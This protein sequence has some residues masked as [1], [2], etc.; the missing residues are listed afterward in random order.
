MRLWQLAFTLLFLIVLREVSG[1]LLM[2][3][4]GL[5]VLAN[6]GGL[7]V[8]SF[9]AGWMAGAISKVGPSRGQ[10]KSL[11]ALGVIAA[12]GIGFFFFKGVNHLALAVVL[13]LLINMPLSYGCLLLGVHLA[14]RGLEI[15][16][17]HQE[18]SRGAGGE[19]S[20]AESHSPASTGE[21]RRPDQS[22]HR[23]G[24]YSIE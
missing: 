24:E 8:G 17:H 10:L 2:L 12:L 7:A 5:G 6:F 3:L 21:I 13:I 20:L 23:S 11:A 16:P 1:D 18:D 15:Q 22:T 9:C 4:T 19:A 14:E